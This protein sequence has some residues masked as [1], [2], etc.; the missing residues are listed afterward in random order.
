MKNPLLACAIVFAGI[1]AATTVTWAESFPNRPITLVGPYS[2]GGPSD[3]IA[4]LIAEPMSKALGQQ[5]I[6][7]NIVGAGGTLGAAD[8]AS[9][10]PD[11]YTILIHNVGLPAA[12]SLYKELPY[13][14]RSAFEAVGLINTGPM[15]LLSKAALEPK[16]A[17]E[18]FAYLR[19]NGESVSIAHAGIGANSHLC[20]M[21]LNQAMG[22]ELTHVPYS[23]SGPAMT[24]LLGGHIDL[25]CDQSTTAV[26]QV[27]NGAVKPFVVTSDNRLEI[28]PDVPTGI[29]S[30]VPGFSMATWHGLY[31]PK[32]TPDEVVSI[33]NQALQQAL[34][35]PAVIEGFRRV[36]TRSYQLQER[37]PGVHAKLLDEEIDRWA[38]VITS[39]GITAD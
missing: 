32:G 13:D 31:A 10:A 18:L 11:G 6:V 12:A 1:V 27:A 36:G 35:D 25:L 23:G 33:L 2:A 3:A 17:E 20:A 30:G 26:P 22:V 39:A 15:V 38:A 21:L 16:N 24:D 37:S 4:R 34:A 9:A 7:Q 29:E 19:K 5:V 8:V 14:T 28:I